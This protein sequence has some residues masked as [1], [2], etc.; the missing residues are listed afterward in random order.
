MAEKTSDHMLPVMAVM[1]DLLASLR[2]SPN[3]VLIAPP[4]AGK[5]TMMD[6][7][8]GKTRPSSGTVFFGQ[9]FDVT[10]RATYPNTVLYG[11]EYFSCQ[12]AKGMN[13]Q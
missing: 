4:G 3:A 1:S 13:S 9:S 5:T 10:R 8:T 11:S 12:R 7:I 6:V 2:A